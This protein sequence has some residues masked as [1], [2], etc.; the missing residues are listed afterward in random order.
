[1]AP[2]YITRPV[3]RL[4]N[5]VNPNY[6]QIAALLKNAT[7]EVDTAV[8]DAWNLVHVHFQRQATAMLNN[9]RTSAVAAAAQPGGVAVPGGILTAGQT[10]DGCCSS[11]QY[12]KTMIRVASAIPFRP[13]SQHLVHPTMAASY[14]QYLRP[15]MSA[16]Y[17]WDPATNMPF[18]VPAAAPVIYAR[19]NYILRHFSQLFS[20]EANR[21]KVAFANYVAFNVTEHLRQIIQYWLRRFNVLYN[22]SRQQQKDLCERALMLLQPLY[23]MSAIGGNA[24][25]QIDVGSAFLFGN[26]PPYAGQQ[27]QRTFADFLRPI[28]ELV[29]WAVNTITTRDHQQLPANNPPTAAN[30]AGATTELHQRPT[31]SW[32][33]FVGKGNLITFGYAREELGAGYT[34]CNLT[35]G[36]YANILGHRAHIVV[37]DPYNPQIWRPLSLDGNDFRGDSDGRIHVFF[38]LFD[39]GQLKSLRIHPNTGRIVF[40]NR[41]QYFEIDKVSLITNGYTVKLCFEVQV[42]GPVSRRIP[43]MAE[44]QD[45]HDPSHRE[46]RRVDNPDLARGALHQLNRRPNAPAHRVFGVPPTREILGIDPGQKFH[47]IAVRAD[48]AAQANATRQAALNAANNAAL[49]QAVKT[50]F[51][52]SKRVNITRVK[53]R[54]Y[55]EK[56]LASW[57][58]R[59]QAHRVGNTVGLQGKVDYL[60]CIPPANINNSIWGT[61]YSGN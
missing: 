24:V 11:Q 60:G 36:L 22:A 14:N 25:H 43:T 15:A 54:H 29:S 7:E 8:F 23:V 47:V 53:G 5:L 9:C 42:P 59:K 55:R 4:T 57:F 37:R 31:W 52:V 61:I 58:Q 45:S 35:T 46:Y 30:L 40:R 20:I 27:P 50:Q 10:L 6:P 41:Q 51:R 28:W 38:Q 48:I 19:P 17:A 21:M 1:M 12:F 56:S 26:L 2:Y 18:A 44:L 3:G 39:R 49:L 32:Q 34:T 16:N 33:R 13:Q